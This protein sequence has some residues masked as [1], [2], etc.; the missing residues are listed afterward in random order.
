MAQQNLPGLPALS[1]MPSLSDMPA[2]SDT[3][4]LSDM[5]MLADLRM[6]LPFDGRLAWIGV[7]PGRD[8]AM[9]VLPWVDAQ[10]GQGLAGDRYTGR[11]GI[12]EVTL[13]QQEHLAVIASLIDGGQSRRA[14]EAELLRRNLLVSG[15]NLL[16]LQRARFRIGEVILEGTGQCHPCSKMERVLGAGGYNAMR[17]H[18][19]ITARILVRGRLCVGDKVSGLPGEVGK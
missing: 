15:I 11:R 6:R 18:G 8:V 17:G 13:L 16:A 3:P 14:V 1:D 2:L 7:R 9:Q 19:G 4:A 12:R 5:H 10:P